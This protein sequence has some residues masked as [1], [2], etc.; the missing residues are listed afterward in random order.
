MSKPVIVW[1]NDGY[2]VYPDGD[3]RTNGAHWGCAFDPDQLGADA[4]HSL[5]AY[6]GLDIVYEEE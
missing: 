5:I 2:S 1:K 4:V 3:K 6:L